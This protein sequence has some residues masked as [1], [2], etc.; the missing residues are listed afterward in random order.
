[1]IEANSMEKTAFGE[2]YR[3][4]CEDPQQTS[5]RPD[6]PWV[7]GGV[8]SDLSGRGEGCGSVGVELPG[9]R[10]LRLP[11]CLRGP[12]R[13]RER[14]AGKRNR[15]RSPSGRRASGSFA[16]PKEG[17]GS[18]V[19]LTTQPPSC[20]RSPGPVGAD[21]DDPRRGPGARGALD[22]GRRL[23]GPLLSPASA[24]MTLGGAAA[25]SSGTF[26]GGGRG[27]E[28]PPSTHALPWRWCGAAR[29]S[30]SGPRLSRAAAFIWPPRPSL[31]REKRR[32]GDLGLSLGV[33]AS[34]YP[35]PPREE[36]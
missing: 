28:S 5:A 12:R 2:E 23:S 26:T 16:P 32:S 34:P 31:S 6:E 24:V 33:C 29:C 13:G 25:I 20:H 3:T 14:S 15:R 19:L 17:G 21:T 27:G 4:P 8:D 7:R 11:G 30:G 10:S 35:N 9:A 22:T 36:A 18:A 1:M